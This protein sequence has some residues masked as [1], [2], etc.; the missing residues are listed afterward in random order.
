MQ[1]T[2]GGREEKTIPAGATITT[3]IL[4]ISGARRQKYSARV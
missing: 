4:I 2:G 3:S 1:Q